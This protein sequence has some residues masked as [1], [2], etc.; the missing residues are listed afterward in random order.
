MWKHALACT[1]TQVQ[2]GSWALTH[3]DPPYLL[4]P[5][6]THWHMPTLR[7]YL[8]HFRPAGWA[9]PLLCG[10]LKKVS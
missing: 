10:L 7:M 9:H 2:L 6:G 3:L 8:G 4:G 5:E 1:H